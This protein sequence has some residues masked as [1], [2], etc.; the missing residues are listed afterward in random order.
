MVF[1]I[2]IRPHLHLEIWFSNVRE[3]YLTFLWLIFVNLRNMKTVPNFWRWRVKWKEICIRH[4]VSS[5]FIKRNDRNLCFVY[6]A[7]QTSWLIIA[8]KFDLYLR[9]ALTTVLSQFSTGNF[10]IC[11]SNVKKYW[12]GIYCKAIFKGVFV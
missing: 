6:L 7:S 9:L 2:A 4:F 3:M 1:V 11:Y 8:L 12:W 5:V 10:V